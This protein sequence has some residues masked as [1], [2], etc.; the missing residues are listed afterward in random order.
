LNF[1]EQELKK[2]VDAGIDLDDVK[3]A[4]R[5]CYGDLGGQNR[6]KLEFYDE[7]VVNNFSTLKVDIL[8]RTGGKVD[9]LLLRFG[10]I[11]GN[12]KNLDNP[13]LSENLRRNGVIPHI[14]VYG[15][16]A[17]WYAYNP[18]TADLK[19]LA[20]EVNTYLSV[21]KERDADLDRQKSPFD[22]AMSR[23]KEKSDEYKAQKAQKPAKTK[24][25]NKKEE[26][27]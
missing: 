22:K 9:S 17:E 6:A 11:W 20:D 21:F 13:N 24:A 4:G 14:W 27:E 23:G 1:F 25:T 8:N 5:A 12:K 26:I 10:E 2:L 15:G 7:S 3:F 18:T 16:K 19:L